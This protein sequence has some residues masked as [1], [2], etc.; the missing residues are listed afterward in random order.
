V[1]GPASIVVDL[2][3]AKTATFGCYIKL[4]MRSQYVITEVGHWGWYCTKDCTK[5]PPT[6]TPWT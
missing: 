4:L 3:Q 1:I 6:L 5:Y 2:A